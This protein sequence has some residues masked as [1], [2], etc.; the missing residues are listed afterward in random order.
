MLA[1]R[2]CQAEGTENAKALGGK[3][4]R[5]QWDGV[6]RTAGDEGGLAL[7][8]KEGVSTGQRPGLPGERRAAA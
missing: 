2:V 3:R 5:G 4:L 6:G 8:T 1:G 7:L